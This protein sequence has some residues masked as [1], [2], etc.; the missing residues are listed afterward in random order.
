MVLSLQIK[1]G[2]AEFYVDLVAAST[3]QDVKIA[4]TA[5]CDIDPELM[6]ASDA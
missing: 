4:S 6:K 2:K 5:G 1:T 3:V